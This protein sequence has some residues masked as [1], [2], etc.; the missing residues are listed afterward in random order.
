[1]EKVKKNDNFFRVTMFESTIPLKTGARD[2]IIDITKRVK[3]IITEKGIKDGICLVFVPHTTAAVTVNESSDVTVGD[4]FIKLMKRIIPWKSIDY[5]HIEGNAAAHAKAI[6]VGSSVMVPIA[7]GKLVL[8]TWQGI[9][10]CE[11]DGPRSRKVQIF[12]R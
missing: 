8:G 5:S 12:L 9:L 10:F 2:Q 7:G 3:K 11:F 6:M 4:D 1:V